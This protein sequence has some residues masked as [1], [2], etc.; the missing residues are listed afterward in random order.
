MRTRLSPAQIGLTLAL[1]LLIGV[2]PSSALV[3]CVSSDGCA[4]LEISL[5]GFPRCVERDCDDGHRQATNDEHACRDSPVYSAAP[6]KA[7]SAID[8]IAAPALAFDA[9]VPRP[10]VSHH[11]LAARPD[12]AAFETAAAHSL[13]TTILLL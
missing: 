3:L 5:P 13:R 9:P 11:D 4:A 6:A 7:Q 1:Q 10:I 2:A 8:A 12:L